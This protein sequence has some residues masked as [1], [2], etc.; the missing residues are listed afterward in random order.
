MLKLYKSYEK[1]CQCIFANQ[2]FLKNKPFAITHD[3]QQ[4]KN[5]FVTQFKKLFLNLKMYEN[6]KLMGVL[7]NSDYRFFLL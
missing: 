7:W 3:F 1:D 2:F 4:M 6:N 5:F